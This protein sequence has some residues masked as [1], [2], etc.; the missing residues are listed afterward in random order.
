MGTEHLSDI[1]I[2]KL[3]FKDSIILINDNVEEDPYQYFESLYE[4][5]KY[6]EDYYIDYN[7]ESCMNYK[8]IVFESIN[9]SIRILFICNKAKNFVIID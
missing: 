1:Q 9:K 7:Y 8:M 3:I 2:E 5:I 6:D 4:H